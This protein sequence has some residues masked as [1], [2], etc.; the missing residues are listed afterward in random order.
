MDPAYLSAL[1]A[2]AGTLIGGLTSF[3]TSYVSLSVQ[4]NQARLSAQR[5]KR[6]ELYGG[7]LTQLAVLFGEALE[8]TSMDYGKLAV[9]FGLKG[10]L[11]LIAS[12]PVNESAEAALKFIM[13]LYLAPPATGEEVRAMMDNGNVD[14]IGD[15][16]RTCRQEMQ[17]LGLG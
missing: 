14:P 2:L 16:A 12:P 7:F 17:T 1:S 6:E 5:A 8:S 13:E 9:A 10:R 4:A 15:F 11:I 3:F